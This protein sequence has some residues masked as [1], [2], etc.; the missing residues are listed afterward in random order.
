MVRTQV[1]YETTRGGER[2]ELV[3]G[4]EPFGQCS[5]SRPRVPS[6]HFNSLA[7]ISVPIFVKAVACSFCGASPSSLT[8]VRFLGTNLLQVIRTFERIT[9]IVPVPA[10]NYSA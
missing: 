10:S 1:K 4:R 2:A 9:P 3:G 5:E 7:Y 8:N 6:L